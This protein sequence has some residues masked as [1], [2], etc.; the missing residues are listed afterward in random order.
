MQLSCVNNYFLSL[1]NNERFITCMYK[2]Q[3]IIYGKQL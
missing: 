1:L 3:I 2:Q